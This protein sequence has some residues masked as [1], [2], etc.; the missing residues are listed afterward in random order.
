VYGLLA[1]VQE[2]SGANDEVAAAAWFAI[3]VEHRLARLR[4]ENRARDFGWARGCGLRPGRLR[5]GGLFQRLVASAYGGGK[6]GRYRHRLQQCAGGKWAFIVI[7]HCITLE[8][9]PAAT[10]NGAGK[11]AIMQAFCRFRIARSDA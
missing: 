4:A 1:A 6:Q 5:D 8:S 10:L 7:G 2:H 9:G 3:A 11:M